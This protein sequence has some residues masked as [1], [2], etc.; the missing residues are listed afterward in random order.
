MAVRPKVFRDC[1]VSARL[2][3]GAFF[4]RHRRD[5]GFPFRVASLAD[6]PALVADEVAGAAHA[7]VVVAAVLVAGIFRPVALSGADH[8]SRANKARQATRMSGLLQW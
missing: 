3:R 5:M 7:F 6:V 4:G 8:P 2:P 1:R